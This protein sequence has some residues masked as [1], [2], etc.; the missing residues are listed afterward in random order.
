MRASTGVHARLQIEQADGSAQPLELA[1]GPS[2]SMGDLEDVVG[3]FAEAYCLSIG[4]EAFTLLE[5][6]LCLFYPELLCVAFDEA[7]D[8][9]VDEQQ[10]MSRRFAFAFVAQLED[11]YD[12]HDPW[13]VVRPCTRDQVAVW[14]QLMGL[15]PRYSVRTWCLDE[16]LTDRFQK[17]S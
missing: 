4:A 10:K 12:I 16:R 5:L 17:N 3:R 8:G 2:E 15:D 1:L 6:R 7:E 14:S 13:L 9:L 11:H